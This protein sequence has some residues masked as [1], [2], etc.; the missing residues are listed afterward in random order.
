MLAQIYT[1]IY[2]SLRSLLTANLLKRF[3]PV[4]ESVIRF[5]LCLRCCLAKSKGDCLEFQV[6]VLG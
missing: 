5:G 4:Q 2:I 3:R 1:Y 6:L